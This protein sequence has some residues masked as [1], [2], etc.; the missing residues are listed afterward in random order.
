MASYYFIGFS[1]FTM[2]KMIMYLAIIML[3]I[4]KCKSYALLCESDYSYD[5][6][7]DCSGNHCCFFVQNGNDIGKCC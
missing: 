3:L 7:I 5:Y 2:A 1:T 6:G 4:I